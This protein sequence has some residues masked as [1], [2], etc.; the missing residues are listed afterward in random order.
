MYGTY[1]V[2]MNLYY[3]YCT[4]YRYIYRHDVI[5]LLM[6]T[7][8]SRWLPTVMGALQ[9]KLVINAALGFDSYMVMRHGTRKRGQLISVL[10]SARW[11]K[12]IKSNLPVLSYGR[13]QSPRRLF[14]HRPAGFRLPAGVLLLQRRGGPRRLDAGSHLGPAVHRHQAWGIVPGRRHRCGADGE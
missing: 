5:F 13:R 1:T 9:S 14:P 2:T 8:E 3:Y 12:K 6:D 11:E 7:R 10:S 4:I